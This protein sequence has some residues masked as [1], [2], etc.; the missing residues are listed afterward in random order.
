MLDSGMLKKYIDE[1]S[2]TGLTPDPTIFD[3]AISNGHTYDREIKRLSKAGHS[4]KALFFDL[5]LQ[6][7]S[8]A[9][10]EIQGARSREAPSCPRN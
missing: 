6:D 5:A 8:R 3:N 4:S 10:D 9:A 7:L 1:F 2:A